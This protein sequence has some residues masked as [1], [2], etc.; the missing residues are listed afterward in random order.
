MRG[1][2][3]PATVYAIAHAQSGGSVAAARTLEDCWDAA[4]AVDDHALQCII[5]HYLAD[6]QRDV[7]DELLWDQR[8]L[9]SHGRVAPGGFQALGVESAEHLLPSLHLNLGDDWLRA[10]D[11]VR[12]EYHL[13]QGTAARHVLNDDGYGQMIMRG[14]DGLADRLAQQ[15]AD[16]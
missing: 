15:S 9:E 11:L 1:Q 2:L 7:A 14:L 6:L 13:R 5:A 10:G 12:A 4:S 16:G 8:A 3:W